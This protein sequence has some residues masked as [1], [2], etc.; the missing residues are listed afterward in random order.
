MVRVVLKVAVSGGLIFWLLSGIELDEIAKLL[1]RL[2][3]LGLV[4][5][6]GL[7][8]LALSIAALRWQL[9]L[10][11]WGHSLGLW[12]LLSHVLVGNF[13]NQI[14]PSSIGGD[15]VRIWRVSRAGLSLKVAT[16]SII[17][18]RLIG[19]AGLLILVVMGQFLSS[20]DNT[21]PVQ[22][23]LVFLLIAAGTAAIVTAAILDKVPLPTRMRRWRWLAALGDLSR[24]FRSVLMAPRLAITLLMV[25]T[26]MQAAG[27]L[28]VYAISV[29]LEIP[30][31]WLDHLV[32]VPPALL[33]A[34]LPI[35]MAGWGVREAVLVYS[36]AFVGVAAEN[37]LAVSVLFGVMSIFSGLPGAVLWFMTNRRK[38]D[39]IKHVSTTGTEGQSPRIGDD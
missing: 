22:N 31:G 19:A 33:M 30:V 2:E 16:N 18:D 10:A 37:A 3:P 24:D 7:I 5:S 6:V 27:I 39:E 11:A 28:S 9:L 1:T 26:V 12:T 21:D 25:S 23:E 32:L 36:F 29:A 8:L 20:S 4:C 13:F 17:I 15:A 38:L 14:L 35:S 34:M